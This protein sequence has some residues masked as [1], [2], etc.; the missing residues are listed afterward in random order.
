MSVTWQRPLSN[1]ITELFATKAAL[2]SRAFN[3]ELGMFITL[4]D[5][6][7]LKFGSKDFI[8]DSVS[9][10]GVSVAVT[11]VTFDARVEGSPDIREAL[12]RQPDAGEFELVNLD[13][14]ISAGYLDT[15]RVFDNSEAVIYLCF[16]KESGAYEGLII[17]QGL[18]ADLT[19]DDETSRMQV[20]SKLS[21][22]GAVVGK[23]ITQRCINELGD[24]WC[25]VPPSTLPVG[26]ICSKLWSDKKAGCLYWGGVYNGISFINPNGTVNGYNGTLPGGGFET[27]GSEW[28]CPSP[29]MWFESANGGFIQGY[30]LKFGEALLDHNGNIGM[31]EYA[32]R[33]TA[34]F[35]FAIDTRYGC[36]ALVSTTHKFI[37]GVDDAK[38]R[39]ANSWRFG[40]YDLVCRTPSKG[41]VLAEHMTVADLNPNYYFKPLGEGEVLKLKISGSHIYG[42]GMNKGKMIYH[43]NNKWHPQPITQ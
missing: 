37:T 17:F 21:S 31:V 28:G 24:N 3:S 41:V 23:E 34:P 38:G 12:G 40:A 27:G 16:P 36:Q 13:Y 18:I 1:V 6:T 32:E 43:H 19:S 14:A 25:G 2:N 9:L 42:A 33:I 39:H 26:A 10:N 15:D 11:P 5:L 29:E 30:D 20:I 7:T 35:R 22:T 4:K 8:M